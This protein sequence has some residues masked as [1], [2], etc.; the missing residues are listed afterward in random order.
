MK[1]LIKRVYLYF[2]F[3]F[4]MIRRPPRSTLFPYTTLFRSRNRAFGIQR[5]ARRWIRA[6]H[7]ELFLQRG[8]LLLRELRSGEIRDQELDVLSIQTVMRH[9]GLGAV[10]KAQRIAE[11]AGKELVERL[12]AEDV[13]IGSWDDVVLRKML[14]ERWQ[15]PI[16][17]LLRGSG[18]QGFQL[19]LVLR[20]VSRVSVQNQIAGEC[21]GAIG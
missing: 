21:E 10:L 4:L 7:I 3:F 9:F 2:F 19:P 16:L 15:K 13:A 5:R 8:Q 1:E 17:R 6:I 20:D 14:P 18:D 11:I 12:R